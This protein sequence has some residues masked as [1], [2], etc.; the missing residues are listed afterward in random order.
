MYKFLTDAGLLEENDHASKKLLTTTFTRQ[1]YLEY[2]K[3]TVSI[4]I[5]VTLEKKLVFTSLL[6]SEI[7]IVVA[8]Y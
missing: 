7:Y 5:E 1:M 4:Y 6:F 8:R 3:I 2:S